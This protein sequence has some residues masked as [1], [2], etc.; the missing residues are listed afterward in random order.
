LRLYFKYLICILQHSTFHSLV[1]SVGW[2]MAAIVC[3][4]VLRLSSYICMLSCNQQ[5]IE[6]S[7]CFELPWAITIV[8]LYCYRQ[9]LTHCPELFTYRC[10]PGCWWNDSLHIMTYAKSSRKSTYG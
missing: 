9:P 3:S 5:M 10:L 1:G 4:L 6:V 8:L 2:W 7:W